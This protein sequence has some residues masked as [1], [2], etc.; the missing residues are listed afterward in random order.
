MYYYNYYNYNNIILL[1]KDVSDTIKHV[2]LY[3]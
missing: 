3:I 1:F 2:E